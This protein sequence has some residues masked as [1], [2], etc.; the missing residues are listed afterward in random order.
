MSILEEAKEKWTGTINTVTLGALREEGGT[1]TS[2]VKVG[3][4]AS[5]PF[6]RFEGAAPHRSVVAIEIIIGLAATMMLFS[7]QYIPMKLK[8]CKTPS[9]MPCSMASF[10]M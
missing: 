1:R 9:L 6:M 8:M 7:G 4:S 10:M 5:L 3:G 2:Q